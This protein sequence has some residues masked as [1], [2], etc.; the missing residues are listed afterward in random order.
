MGQNLMTKILLVDDSKL[1]MGFG[2]SILSK[3]GYEV[4]Y[5]QNG[6]EALEIV[7]VKKP[8]LI[9]LDVVMPGMDGYEVCKRL[10]A[11][12]KTRDIP[13]IMLTS[14]GETADKIKG[15]NLGAVDYITKPFDAGELTA[16]VKTQLRVKELHKALQ[17]KNRQLQ[18]LANKD[19]LTDLYNHRYL[20]ERL[21]KEIERAK[22]YRIDLSFVLIDIDYFKHFNDTYGHQTGDVILKTLGCI[23]KK[24]LRESD[25][26]A[27]Y[28]GEEFALILVHTGFDTAQEAAER[29]RS[30]VESYKFEVDNQNFQ[31]TI[32]L[33]IASF[34]QEMIN[35]AKDLVECADK[36]LYTAKKQGRNRIA[37]YRS[38]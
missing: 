36:A 31:V 3:E 21:I 24:A 28:G 38:E 4:T 8:D 2:K 9:L 25:T 12:E 5:A 17:E 6:S 23:L 11:N 15:L 27:R 26:A 1:I 19:G 7:S 32:S 20:Q 34:E 35:T 16:R 22:R 10:K 30:T 13:I 37:I 14:K 33:G 18:E 29:L